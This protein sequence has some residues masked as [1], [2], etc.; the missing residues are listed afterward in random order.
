MH[1]ASRVHEM[2]PSATQE[3]GEDRCYQYPRGNPPPPQKTAIASS[4]ARETAV[5]RRSELEHAE[6]PPM[7]ERPA[8]GGRKP[9]P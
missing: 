9:D 6:V 3:G 5:N 1:K 8:V 2:A 4:K 7:K